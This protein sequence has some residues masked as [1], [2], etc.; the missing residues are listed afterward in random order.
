MASLGQELRKLR[1]SRNISIEE[2]ASS[3]KIIGRYIQAVEED[4][5]DAMPGGFFILGIIRSY[6]KYLGL[7]PDETLRRYRE[8]GL[9]PKPAYTESARATAEPPLEAARRSPA[10]IAGVAVIAIVS[11]AVIFLWRARRPHPSA[12]QVKTDA[13]VTEVQPVTPPQPAPN[14]ESTAQAPIEEWRGV[15]IDISFQDDTWIRVYADGVLKV[16]GQFPAGQKARASADK[17]LVLEVGNAGG[18]TFLLNGKPAKSLGRTAQVLKDV[19]ITPE[20]M[21]EFLERKDAPASPTGTTGSG[22]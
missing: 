3:T 9:I 17:E 19:R 20:N 2:I 14:P 22:H 15:T 18:M 7:D 6:A 10:R 16:E 11:I 5:F 12:P 13:A 1:E 4:R 21:Q 8:A